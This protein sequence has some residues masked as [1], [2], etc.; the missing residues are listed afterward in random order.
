MPK[1]ELAREP[2]PIA[3]VPVAFVS[4]SLCLIYGSRCRMASPEFG[5]FGCSW[6][7]Q[8]S[9]KWGMARCEDTQR[10][11]RLDSGHSV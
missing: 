1:Q 2:R 10:L 6:C 9:P 5:I 11:S 3:W 8:A 4:I 7:D